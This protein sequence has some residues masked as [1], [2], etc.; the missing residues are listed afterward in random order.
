MTKETL[1]EILHILE[2]DYEAEPSLVYV[3]YRTPDGRIGNFSISIRLGNK[4]SNSQI[5]KLMHREYPAT[6]GTTTLAVE[7]PDHVPAVEWLDV[8][9]VC[10]ILHVSVRTLR[11]WT[12]RGIFHPSLLGRKLYY[13]RDEI[14][15]VLQRNAILD[16]GRFD[17]T[18]INSQEETERN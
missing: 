17:N 16:N 15:D 11:N 7:R 8:A 12:R 13:S 9:D 5:E 14:E 6:R 2:L 4:M 10:R 3:L 18:A 1:Q